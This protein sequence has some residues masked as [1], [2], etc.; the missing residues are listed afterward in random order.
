MNG[1][2]DI[3]LLQPIVNSSLMVITGADKARIWNWAQFPPDLSM[4]RIPTV[5]RYAEVSGQGRL[6][7]QSYGSFI[8][9]SSE[10]LGNSKGQHPCAIFF[11]GISVALSKVIWNHGIA[12]IP[13]DQLP[14]YCI[15]S[16]PVDGRR[17][18]EGFI[19]RLRRRGV[20]EGSQIEV[21]FD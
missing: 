10:D 15:P 2:S 1:Y 11:R 13:V 12:S 20:Y 19:Q 9:Q 17:N 21:R 6:W 14:V 16:A 5:F 7:D 8:D 3:S 18:I 4:L